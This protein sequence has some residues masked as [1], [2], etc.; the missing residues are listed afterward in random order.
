MWCRPDLGSPVGAALTEERTGTMV[1]SKIRLAR[2]RTMSC[3]VALGVLLIA[4]PAPAHSSRS[5]VADV[6]RSQA[7]M[8][9]VTVGRLWIAADRARLQL[10]ELSDGYFIIDGAAPSAVFVN[11]AAR[12]YMDAR[13]SSRL[14]QWFVPVDPAD[15]CRQWQAMARLAGEPDHGSWHCERIGE[16]RARGHDAFAVRA[17]A[18][19]EPQFIG[20]V[21]PELGFPVRVELADG[22]TF[23]VETIR[24]EPQTAESMQVPS[25]FHKFDP[26]ALIERIKQ[27]DVWVE[28]H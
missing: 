18:G 13:R 11:L 9:P 14:T 10:A 22:T 25:G 12:T 1:M 19:S 24:E 2:R 28:V 7:G 27:S 17:T 15:P 23:S 16:T 8:A 3:L 21:D 5:V 20:W 26:L 6:V 4:S